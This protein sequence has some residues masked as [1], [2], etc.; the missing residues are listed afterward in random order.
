MVKSFLIDL[1]DGHLIFENDGL[2][3]LVDTGCPVTIG[4]ST[5]FDFMGQSYQCMTEFGRKGIAE[6]SAMMSYDIDV[7]MGMNIIE[8][9]YIQTNYQSKEITF[10]TEDI[11]F[12]SICSTPIIRGR[13][14][15][16]CIDLTIKGQNVRLAL[17][18]GARISYIDESLTSGETM[19]ETRND[20]NPMIGNFSTPIYSMEASICDQA[21]PVNFGK[22]PPVMA[23]PLKMMGIYGAIGFDLFN[24]FTVLMNFKKNMLSLK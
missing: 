6:I 20:F 11:P 12:D 17:D 4:K 13:M 7:F 8:Q 18:T 22:L 19:V 21:F 23:M 14:G 10:S 3:V 5:H 2:K 9:F 1:F 24:A 15:E 16:V